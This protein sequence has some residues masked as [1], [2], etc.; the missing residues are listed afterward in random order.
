MHIEL[1]ISAG[2]VG[3]DT[4][5]YAASHE[6][7]HFIRQ[8]DEQGYNDY[9]K[10]L[11]DNYIARG[12]SADELIE[13]KRS[14]LSGLEQYNEYTESELYEIAR[15]EVICDASET[16]LKDSDAFDNI[17]ALRRKNNSLAKAIAKKLGEIVEASKEA[18]K[19]LPSGNYYARALLSNAEIFADAK[20]L[21][22]KALNT[23]LANYDTIRASGKGTGS[24]RTNYSIGVLENGNTFVIYDRNVITSS[25]V[26]TMR[27]QITDFFGKLT[28]ENGS[29]EITAIDGDVLTITRENTGYKARDNFKQ[30][31]GKKVRLTE[32]E[33][34]LKLRA[35]SHIDELSEVSINRDIRASDTKTHD[36]AKDGF[37]YKTAFFKD[38]DGQYYRITLSIGMNDDVATVYNVGRIKKDTLPSVNLMTVVGSKPLGSASD[39]SI[40]DQNGFVN[41]FDKKRQGEKKFSI[42]EDFNE[43]EK[44]AVPITVKDVEMLREITKAHGG[45]RVSIN[46]FTS[47]DVQ[48]SKEWARKFY[49][50]LGTK[51]PFFRAWFGEWRAHD[52][53]RVNTSDMEDRSG[54]NPRGQYRNNDTGWTIN[55]SSVG[56]DET[57]SHS[58]KDKKSVIAMRNIDKIIENSILLDTETSEYGRGKKSI[59]TAFMH[60]F[61]APITID[62]TFYIAKMAVDESYLPGQNETNKKFYHVRSIEIEEVPSV[63]IGKSH[64]PIMENTSS[65]YTVSDII[66]LVKRFD[67]DFTPARDVAPDML[68]EDGTPKVFYHGT[69]AIFSAFDMSKGRANMDIQGAF[70]SMWKEEAAGYG[71]KVGEYY[72]NIQNPATEEIGY[73]ALNKYKGQNEAGIKAKRYLESLGYDGV[74]NYD[75]VIA[76][77]PT[78]IKSATDNIGTF[79]G[80][81]N[82]IRYSVTEEELTDRSILANALES[83]A[84]TGEDR[85]ILSDYKENLSRVNSL[86]AELNS[87][88][89]EI[90]RMFSDES[91]ERKALAEEGINYHRSEA[92]RDKYSRL[93]K[94][95]DSLKAKIKSEDARLLSLEAT[96][97][98]K[99]VLDFERT[100]I[101]R[102]GKARLREYKLGRARSQLRE[103]ISRRVGRLN[104]LLLRDDKSKHIPDN[105]KSSVASLLSFIDMQNE[106]RYD[107]Y[108]RDIN[109]LNEQIERYIAD[110]NEAGIVES[111][112]K[113]QA[114]E[115]KQESYAE[116]LREIGK[117]YA[118]AMGV[119]G[120]SEEIQ[121]ELDGLSN[122]IGNTPIRE[123]SNEQLDALNK[124]LSLAESIVSEEKA[125]RIKERQQDILDSAEAVIDEVKQSAHSL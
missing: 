11:F 98:L 83:A 13:R 46:D 40:S 51:S 24:G 56:Y 78:Q 99:K 35:E 120:Y 57:M 33:F 96:K 41:T 67:K 50:E 12:E 20:K 91:K 58:G 85:K 4:L 62:G 93:K 21:W 119:D 71:E 75:E 10:F 94:K 81:N 48:K 37:I 8:F 15:E 105:L 117:A 110:G 36:F 87:V 23:A 77:Y 76:F 69:D 114:K 3:A 97:S 42:T 63:G 16:M 74:V 34:A 14:F 121:G 18:Y 61:Y 30:E 54:K 31:G 70:F 68:N 116:R 55:S 17:M 118:D 5:M 88:D 47:E 22:E 106:I 102:E 95:S 122:V 115:Q 27:Q 32:S 103:T 49:R 26:S 60:K 123:M 29:I 107:N 28:G 19:E 100:R 104:T 53:T 59:Y 101:R 1:D 64:T 52:S 84:Q 2:P 65:A 111:A 43:G 25:D 38:Y 113:L 90:H 72:L 6:L 89:E 124:S 45:K 73:K 80:G 79:D 44:A 9:A 92:F 125:N 86:Q 108:T 39:N 7:T 66:S 82:D 109:R 112:Y